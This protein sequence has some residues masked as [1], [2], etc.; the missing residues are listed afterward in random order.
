MQPQRLSEAA[1]NEKGA[2]AKAAMDAIVDGEG[3]MAFLNA[4]RPDPL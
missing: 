2:E 3:Y 1:Y 4:P